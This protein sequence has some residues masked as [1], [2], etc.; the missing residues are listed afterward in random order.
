MSTTISKGGKKMN[1]LFKSKLPFITVA[2]VL[3]LVLLCGAVTA[4]APAD[5]Y[6]DAGY[7]GGDSDGSL[8]KPFTTIG[9]A[10]TAAS[11]GNI[12][13]VTAGVYTENVTIDKPITLTGPDSGSDLP[14][15]K[16]TVNVTDI[17]ENPK[18]IQNINFTLQEGT[19]DNIFLNKAKNVTIEHCNFDAD[20]RFMTPPGVRAIQMNSKCD[21]ITIDNCT[22]MD[23]YYVTIQGNVDG[24]TVKNSVIENCKSGINLLAGTT[25]V[26]ENTDISVVAKGAANDT[27]CVRFA[28]S[29]TNSGQDMSITGGTFTVDRAGLLAEAGTY[30]SAIVIREGAT[31]TLEVK[32]TNIRG[33]VVNL[34][35]T[36][37]NAKYNCWGHFTLDFMVE[38]FE[39]KVDFSPWYADED[40]TVLCELLYIVSGGTELT[41]DE[42]G[43][44]MD[45]ETDEKEGYVTVARYSEDEN[46]APEGMIPAG[47]YLWIERS[48]NLANASAHIDIPYDP[49]N[50]PDGVTEDDLRLYRYNETTEKWDLIP[51]Q[52]IDKENKI[53]W[54]ELDHFSKF[55]IFAEAELKP[56]EP[57]PEEPESEE[58]PKSD[59][60]RTSG[61]L[62]YLMIPGLAGLTAGLLLIRGKGQLRN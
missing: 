60:P 14:L 34:S 22:F 32:N 6:V 26:V 47:I 24:L 62:L 39:D 52:G 31:G 30:H 53:L 54:A 50:L 27:Y 42:S 45:I 44:V 12:I 9:E 48:D 36:I 49:E 57:E 2:V 11:D 13:S 37:L 28:S 41:F 23:G 58:K 38:G 25:L 15:I 17:S 10:I 55:G 5:W 20:G 56:E 29:T 16:G 46:D 59:L 3:V 1:R 21:G 40:L 4:G 7:V 43:V 8:E 61:G 18:T 19:I 35:K 33:E 51:T